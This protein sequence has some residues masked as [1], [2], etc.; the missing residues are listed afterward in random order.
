MSFTKNPIKL[1][2]G[3]AK[4]QK[5]VKMFFVLE[6]KLFFDLMMINMVH[7]RIKQLLLLFYVFL[8][9]FFWL[10]LLYA[11]P[12]MLFYALPPPNQT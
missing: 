2:M 6:S 3:E 9:R 5:R 8:P 10:I 7:L 12:L 4:A 11:F 1:L